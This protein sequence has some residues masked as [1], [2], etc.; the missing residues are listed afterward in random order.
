MSPLLVVVLAGV[1]TFALRVCMIVVLG[2]VRVTERVEEG[3]RLI[4]PAALGALVAQGLLL[5]EG[6]IRPLDSWYA[7]AAIAAV[8]A[9]R[10][11][12]VG[13]TLA[14]GMGALWLIQFVV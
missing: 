9:W 7:A 10:T 8:V 13:W 1:G 11:G 5:S 12:S 2:R 14:G 4:A 6:A 3:L